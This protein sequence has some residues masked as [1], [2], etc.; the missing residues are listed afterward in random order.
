MKISSFQLQMLL[1]IL[2]DSL[3]VTRDEINFGISRE[4]RLQLFNE[5]LNQQSNELQE[6][7]D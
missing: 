3:S 6:I 5:I 1:T 4:R 7:K 2:H